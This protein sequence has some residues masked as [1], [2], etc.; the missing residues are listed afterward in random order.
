MTKLLTKSELFTLLEEINLL[1]YFPNL[2]LDLILLALT[3]KDKNNF[4]DKSLTINFN[5]LNEL[6]GLKANDR[7]YESLEFYGDSVLDM[8]IVDIIKARFWLSLNPGLLTQVKSLLVKNKTLTKISNELTICDKVFGSKNVQ[9]KHNPCADSFEAIIGALYFQYGLSS[10]L[11][12]KKW[13]TSLQNID[14]LIEKE[15]ETAKAN[16]KQQELHYF[17]TQLKFNKSG[18]VEK[19]MDEYTKKYNFMQFTKSCDDV[20]CEIYLEN[21]D[22]NYKYYLLTFYKEFGDEWKLD[23]KKSLQDLKIWI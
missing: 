3:P 8:I 14:L 7:N 17:V 19:F 18:D 9:K 20:K 23:L 2:D 6:Y 10:L 13:L 1:E 5:K 22:A 21:K 11:R 16:I 12:I 15:F 4:L